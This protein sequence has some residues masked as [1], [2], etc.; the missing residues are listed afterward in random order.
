MSS[1]PVPAPDAETAP[2]WDAAAEGVLKI[3]KCAGCGEHVFYPR[4]V[5]P[6]CMSEALEW[7]CV[8]GR[9]RIHALT[10]VHR[11]T[12]PFRDDLPFVV[13]IVELEEGPRMMTR[14]LTDAPE[15]LRIDDAVKV[16]FAPQGDG[17]PLPFFEPA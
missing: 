15:A 14:V 5:C 12:A 13:A 4:L 3:Q 7:V 2:F 17:P 9:A 6:H 8:S 16:H 11:S 10:V 1:K